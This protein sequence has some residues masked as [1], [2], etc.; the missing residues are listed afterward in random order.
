M[1]IQIDPPKRPTGKLFAAGL[2][3]AV[4]L[5][6]ISMPRALRALFVTMAALAAIAGFWLALS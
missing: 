3:A 2:L 6:V 5:V 1:P 4:L